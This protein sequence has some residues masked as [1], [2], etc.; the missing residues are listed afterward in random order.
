[1]NSFLWVTCL[2]FLCFSE[3]GV[4]C[5]VVCLALDVCW[6][7]ACCS[8]EF[9]RYGGLPFPCF[10]FSVCVQDPERLLHGSVQPLASATSRCGSR[11]SCFIILF[12]DCLAAVSTLMWTPLHNPPKPHLTN[13]VIFCV[14][15]T[16]PVA[17]S[18]LF[19]CSGDRAKH[20]IRL[21]PVPI[22]HQQPSF[23][24]SDNGW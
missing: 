22:I 3:G 5:F 19:S 14:K 10:A 16:D 7:T 18:P 23:P 11:M 1:M 8:V 24:F 20:R 6:V 9:G 21:K 2:T 13:G 15:P 12:A 17:A 4:S